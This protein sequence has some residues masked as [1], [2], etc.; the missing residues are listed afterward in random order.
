MDFGIDPADLIGNLFAHLVEGHELDVLTREALA[1]GILR[2]VRRGE[3]LDA[4]LGLSGAGC[5]SLQRRLLILQ[6]DRHLLD[7]V[8][9]CALA[10]ALTDWQ[11]C[12]RLAPLI[13][14]FMVTDWPRVRRLSQPPADW[15][16]WKRALFRAAQTDLPLPESGRRLDQIMKQMPTDSLQ[17]KGG[18][19]L[20]HYL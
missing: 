6:R 1:V 14:R 17:R 12:C 13:K 20:S 15:P 18:M 4:A 9:S 7:A 8:T 16:R 3:S 10:E 5:R 11:R 2:A 19:L